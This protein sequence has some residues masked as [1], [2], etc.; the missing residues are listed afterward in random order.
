MVRM[1]ADQTAEV[2]AKNY[3]ALAVRR[4]ESSCYKTL[5]SFRL[6]ETAPGTRC[7]IERTLS[8]AWYVRRGRHRHVQ[9]HRLGYHQIHRH[10]ARQIGASCRC[11]GE[12]PCHRQI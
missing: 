8:Y 10:H 7:R 5:A 6:D 3:R 2:S 12:D 9:N 1:M 4:A 11:M